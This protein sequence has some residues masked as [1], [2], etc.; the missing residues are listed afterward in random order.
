MGERLHWNGVGKRRYTIGIHNVVLFVSDP[1][2]ET[3]YASGVA[4]DGV[5][6]VNE[7]P[8]GAESNDIYAN[9]S[10][11]ATTRSLEQFGFTIEA[12]TSPEEF[13]QCDGA[14]E[15]GPGVKVHQQNRKPFGLAYCNTIG[16]DVMGMDFSEEL[17]LVYNATASPS[18][19]NRSTVNES[20][21]VSPLSWECVSTSIA[22]PG[23]KNSAHITF[24]K[25]LMSQSNWNILT[26]LVFGCDRNDSTLPTP[27]MIIDLF[28]GNEPVP[29]YD[30]N[31]YTSL[32][33]LLSGETGNVILRGYTDGD[34]TSSTGY[35][36]PVNP[37][38][39]ITLPNS[40]PKQVGF[41]IPC[42]RDNV[43]GEPIDG[44]STSGVFYLDTVD[45]G[46]VDVTY[47]MLRSVY[48]GLANDI[49][50]LYSEYV[51][52]MAQTFH[53]HPMWSE[54]ISATYATGTNHDQ[55]VSALA[56]GDAN[57]VLEMKTYPMAF[58]SVPTRNEDGY[59]YAD[60]YHDAEVL[61]NGIVRIGYDV[62][63]EQQQVIEANAR[64]NYKK[65][66]GVDYPY[67]ITDYEHN[68]ATSP[69]LL[70]SGYHYMTE[71]AYNDWC[72]YTGVV[73]PDTN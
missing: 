67:P 41:Y 4:W 19:A 47:I 64:L 73:I 25:H 62:T 23:F 45:N 53:F 35:T 11:Y 60:Y 56:S 30:G 36:Y 33:S 58:S 50:M 66:Y 14:A 43:T 22:I 8:S 15:I 71:E 39:V 10:K 68:L 17:H 52:V 40:T 51:N 38:V 59:S 72:N 70:E 27:Q 24:Y 44:D 32:E 2:T 49:Y 7:S 29:V 6:A 42:E 65:R 26:D 18:S 69:T 61:S 1:T 54:Q 21:D 55:P 63:R 20:P 57:D 34:R 9:D 28:G 12:Y 48:S 46:G 5:S 13:D 3:G 31:A 37:R 16:N